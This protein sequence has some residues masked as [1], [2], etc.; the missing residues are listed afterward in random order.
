MSEL[1]P[2][3]QAIDSERQRQKLSVQELA[4]KAD[5]NFTGLYRIFNGDVLPTLFV[6]N[7]LIDALGMRLVVKR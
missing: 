6:L 3:V 4:L 5:V 7:K 2:S 1:D